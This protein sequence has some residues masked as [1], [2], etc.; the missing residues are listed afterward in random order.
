VV[1]GVVVA[2][3]SGAG[4]GA[5]AVVVD[6]AVVSVCPVVAGAAGA[7]VVG[8]AA[9][10]TVVAGAGAAGAVV[11]GGG[12]GATVVVDGTSGATGV[13]V[14]SVV[15]TGV[16]WSGGAPGGAVSATAAEGAPKTSPATAN[17]IPAAYPVRTSRILPVP[18]LARVSDDLVLSVN[19]REHR[20]RADPETPLLYVLRNDLGLTAAKFGCGLE[21]CY[22][23]AVIVEEEAVTSCATAVGAFVGR[24]ITTLEGIGT[25]ERL[26]P[27]QEAFL[28]EEAAQCGY[29][30]PG[31]IVSAKALI[32]RVPEPSD[33]DIRAALAPHL[34]RCG[35]H[36][37]ILKAVRRATAP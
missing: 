15:V 13:V 30:I 10:A 9:G 1:V 20:V 29:C 18:T 16:V 8:G 24:E 27:L 22:A 37:R 26:H 23:C 5:G 35:S 28:E 33:D 19:G 12:A 17:A 6:A 32:D 11:V 36:A 4:A 3:G 2:V 25:P 7:V 34:C 14:A 21:Q 31:V